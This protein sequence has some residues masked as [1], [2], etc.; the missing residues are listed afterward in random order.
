MKITQIKLIYLL[1]SMILSN[2]SVRGV[3]LK[4]K[5]IVDENI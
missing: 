5:R 1:W 2:Y 4:I 3:L